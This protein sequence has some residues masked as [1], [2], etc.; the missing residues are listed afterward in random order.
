M[1]LS[2]LTTGRA[3]DVLVEI[4]ALTSNIT[5]D[6]QLMD[7]IG[8]VMDFQGLNKRG[9]QALML[10][11]YS[12]FIAGLLKNHREDLFGILAALNDT[13]REEIAARPIMETMR[14]I[15]EIRD[16]E[17]LVRFLSSF[18]RQGGSGSSAPSAT[19]PDTSPHE[20]S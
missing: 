4:T 11:K 7:I 5:E 18:M 16:D 20:G 14:Q 1:K 13:T 2:E 9:V 8:K 12:A 17:D 3:A 15:E 19:V 6:T 10:G